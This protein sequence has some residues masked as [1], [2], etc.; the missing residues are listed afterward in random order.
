MSESTDVLI[1]ELRDVLERQSITYGDFVLVSGARSNYYC[2]TK[3]TVLSPRGAP[4]IG[5]VLYRICRAYD[6]EAIGGLELGAPLMAAAATLASQMDGH[7]IYAFNVRKTQ[8][9]HGKK[10]KVDESWH[11]DGKLLVPERRV[12]LVDDVITSGGSI[13]AAIDEVREIGCDIRAVIGLVDRQAGGGE[14]LLAQGLNY[15]A[16]FHTDTAGKLHVNE[17]PDELKEV[18]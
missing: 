3:L 8:K 9:A 5:E 12:A 16:L 14:K 10:Q 4:L 11:P 13:Q 6:V 1:R 7:P 2:D 18:L 17:L 15:F